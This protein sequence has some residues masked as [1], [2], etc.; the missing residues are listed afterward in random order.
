[1]FRSKTFNFCN[2][3]PRIHQ[4]RSQ[5]VRNPKNFLGC[6]PPDP[7]SRR[8]SCALIAYWNPPFKNP[9][10][11]IAMLTVRSWIVHLTP[12]L[13]CSYH[14]HSGHRFLSTWGA[15]MMLEK[16]KKKKRAKIGLDT[17]IHV[18][19]VMHVSCQESILSDLYDL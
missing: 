19:L 3:T 7:P 5:K 13:G 9:R 11:A 1:M 15:V 16:K 17:C 10:S 4:K 6:K 12:I 14:L 8:A 18:V 2:F